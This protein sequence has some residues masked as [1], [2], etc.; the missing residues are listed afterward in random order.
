MTNYTGKKVAMKDQIP[1]RH[2]GNVALQDAA[3]LTR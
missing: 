2:T 3:P 1:Y